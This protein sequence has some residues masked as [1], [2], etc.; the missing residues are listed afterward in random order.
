M[1]GF[2][3]GFEFPYLETIL[4]AVLAFGLGILWY[5]PK[6]MGGRWL[7]ATGKSGAEI[8]MNIGKF[9]TSLVLWILAA[10]FYSFL[11]IIL[12]ITTPAGFFAL[13]CLLWVA[14]AMPPSLMGSLYTGYSFEAISIDTSYQLAGYYMFAL[15]HLAF[16]F[17]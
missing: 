17:I 6:I 11:V 10:C 2:E 3:I 1:T 8:K 16:I 15:A 5:H 4:S 13:A 12:E 7:E 14:F 9:L